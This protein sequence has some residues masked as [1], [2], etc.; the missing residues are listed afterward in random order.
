MFCPNCGKKLEDSAKFCPYCGEKTEQAA[1]VPAIPVGEAMSVIGA[2]SEKPNSSPVTVGVPEA[3]KTEHNVAD[4]PDPIY[5]ILNDEEKKKGG[6]GKAVIIALIVLLVAAAAIVAV[7]LFGDKGAAGGGQTG[8]DAAV[9]EYDG[10]VLYIKDNDF[11]ISF[12]DSNTNA[13]IMENVIPD[14]VE[15][16]QYQ[17]NFSRDCYYKKETGYL[18]YNQMVIEDG[19]YLSNLCRVKIDG[20][21]VGEYELL[22]ENVSRFEPSYISPDDHKLFYTKNGNLYMRDGE[23]TILESEDSW[24]VAVDYE[25]DICYYCEDD[26]ELHYTVLSS[27]RTGTLY[28]SDDWLTATY[29][30]DGYVVIEDGYDIILADKEG[31]LSYPVSSA[32]DGGYV[33]RYKDGEYYYIRYGFLTRYVSDYVSDDCKEADALIGSDD[34]GYEEKCVRDTIR[35]IVNSKD[36]MDMSNYE[37]YHI[38]DGDF[39]RIADGAADTAMYSD[40]I[41]YSD[42]SGITQV[43][44]VSEIYAELEKLGKLGSF[45]VYDVREVIRYALEKKAAKFIVYKGE[46]SPADDGYYYISDVVYNEE[47]NMI[48]YHADGEMYIDGDFIGTS[49]AY[50]AEIGADNKLTSITAVIEGADNISDLIGDELVAFK[51]M[52]I[53][54]NR[55]ISTGDLYVGEALVDSGIDISYV[56]GP[57]TFFGCAEDGLVIY[58]K[59]NNMSEFRCELY[60]YENS[61]K[62]LLA[63]DV[64]SYTVTGNTLCYYVADGKLMRHDSEAEVDSGNVKHVFLPEM[65]LYY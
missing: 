34:A 4:I 55:Y 50:K 14:G 8:G 46:V 6:K 41:A 63:E 15:R 35:N 25:N 13:L 16:Y 47:N 17:Y 19:Y 45:G 54:E 64:A 38:K 29:V 39:V 62:R 49:Y 48:Y 32:G 59:N 26:T 60:C 1:D 33:S 65:Q 30:G 56:E 42:Y 23:H 57:I 12:T 61:G 44:T 20:E 7:F 40:L 24:I 3:V 11:Y 22:A 51:N 18:Y 31:K 37:I 52:E 5:P 27:R 21:T 2:N 10:F 53:D 58:T 9:E 43:I 36:H 28:E